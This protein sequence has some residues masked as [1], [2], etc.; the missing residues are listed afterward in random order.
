[1]I[2]CEQWQS[3]R[4]PGLG[5]Y[6]GSD[7]EIGD[8]RR[9]RVRGVQRVVDGRDCVQEGGGRARRDVA[10]GCVLGRRNVIMMG[11]GMNV[12]EWE[13]QVGRAARRRGVFA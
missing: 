2:P 8:E 7:V 11:I 5:A 12:V 9:R 3:D 6:V 10:R 13:V 1:M 4:R